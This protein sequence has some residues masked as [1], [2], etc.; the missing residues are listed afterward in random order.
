MRK[1]LFALCL[2]TLLAV[3]C[4]VGYMPWN[5]GVSMSDAR[6]STYQ[7]RV[8]LTVDTSQ[9]VHDDDETGEEE[10][11]TVVLDRP[12]YQATAARVEMLAGHTAKIGWVGTGW[13]AARDANR[14][15]VMTAGHVC[16]SG[17]TFETTII[18]WEKLEFRTVKLPIIEVKHELRDRTGLSVPATVVRDHDLDN[19]F[20]GVD[21]CVLG[22]IADLGQPIPIGDHDPGFG[23]RAEVIGGPTGLWGGGIAVASDAKFSGRGSVFGVEPDGLA[24]NGELAPGNSGSAVIFD[25]HAIGV[26]SLGATRFQ[27]LIHAVPYETMADFLRKALH[28]RS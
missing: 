6:D 7:V 17:D 27:S 1:S 19:D 9:L 24:F 18:D 22:A 5:R 2:L 3:S 15:Y 10:Q 4:N 14:S 12:Q 8:T 11:D 25:G 20:N 23:D 16:E 21:L 28:R 26:I 13:V